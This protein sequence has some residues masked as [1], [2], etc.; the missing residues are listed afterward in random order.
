MAKSNMTTH[1]IS[2]A[3]SFLGGPFGSERG[4]LI[5]AKYEKDA[6]ITIKLNS[7][8]VNMIKM[9]LKDETRC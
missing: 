1:E 4:Y 3:L 6:G 5:S 9:E 7:E 2:E 8:F